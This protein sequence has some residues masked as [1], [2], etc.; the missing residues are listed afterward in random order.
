MRPLTRVWL[1][2]ALYTA[3]YSWFCV[4][5]AV[6][7][8]YGDPDYG[9]FQQSFWTTLNEG[10]LFYNTYES[11]THFSK[12]NSP[13]LFLVLPFYAALPRL[14]TLLVVQTAAI[15]LGAV[16]VF[17]L[18]ALL[19]DEESAVLLAWS[20][21]L[22]H[23]MHGVSYDQFNELAFLPA[24]LLFAFYFMV[25]RRMGWFW[26]CIT[27]SLACKEDV[28]FVTFGLGLYMIWLGR[29]TRRESEP[30]DGLVRH[31]QLLALISVA[32]LLLSLRVIFPLL[33]DGATWPY[34]RERYGQF[35][36]DFTEVALNLLAHPWIIVPYLLRRHALLVLVELTAPLAFLPFRAPAVAAIPLAT[37]VVLQLS[38][39]GAMHNCGSRYMAPVIACMF[40]AAIVGLR[41]VVAATAVSDD[42]VEQ[43]A[44]RRRTGLR[45]SRWVLALTTLSTF[46]L[47][48]TPM[49][50]PFRGIRRPTAHQIARNA[51]AERV[52]ASASVST[53]PEFYAPLSRRADVWLGYHPGTDYVL[54]D[55][56]PD[57]TGHATWFDHARWNVNLP[58]I[59]A[60]GEYVMVDQA[61]GA[62]LLRR[63]PWAMRGAR[64]PTAP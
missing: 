49:R 1:A 24:P 35:G 59:L 55:P 25:Q 58:Q 51:L 56:A 11:G 10:W 27:A 48:T 32:W 21:L 17:K 34:F 43:A 36:R 31:G 33:R 14:E 23:P 6:S 19:V 42:S 44:Q 7:A 63:V 60:R 28:P 29:K 22:Y 9:L 26:A 54:V 50:F 64:R 37:W 8:Y 2:A 45:W 16:A 3:L 4:Q 57:F 53:Q 47:D 12:H 61:D 39:F 40:A 62:V 41:N 18:A 13:I 15:A 30:P 5:R 38:S 52:P 20:Y 46:A